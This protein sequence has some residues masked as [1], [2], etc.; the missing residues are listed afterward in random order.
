VLKEG[1]I[2]TIKLLF[3]VFAKNIKI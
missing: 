3:W 1:L 2:M